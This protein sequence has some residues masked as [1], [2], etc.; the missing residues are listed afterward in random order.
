MDKRIIINKNKKTII[1]KNNFKNLFKNEKIVRICGIHN[2]LIAMLAQEAG[3]DGL[4]L[5]SFEIHASCRLPDADI[6]SIPDY[7]DV[8][9][10]IA[11]RVSIPIM[12][13][14]DCGGGS[15]INTIRMVREY[16]KNGAGGICLE[17]N[18]YPKRCS[19]YG[20]S[21]RKLEN[22]KKHAAKIR[23]A[24]DNR[25]NDSFMVI[26]RIES[27]IIGDSV[28][29]AIERANIY[30]EAGADAILIHHKGES[31]DKIFEFS[32]LM[33]NKIP[34]VC[35]PT[36][37]NSVTEKEL[38]HN[39]FKMV[40]YANCSIRAVV[41]VLQD[42]FKTIIDKKTLSSVNNKIVPMSEIFKL[43]ALE[44]FYDNEKKYM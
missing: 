38:I 29:K 12:V 35:V 24:C 2:A 33:N 3:F 14:G 44:D 21:K 41:K 30:A 37:Y 27:L 10:K 11:D 9:N 4:W 25:L 43:I 13:D 42:V 36:T 28:K 22:P 26:A 34:L 32:A 23:A 6:L 7:S 18:T 15:P 17:D 40:I 20:N 31:P 19:F 8:I 5:S 16:E 39:G 1:T